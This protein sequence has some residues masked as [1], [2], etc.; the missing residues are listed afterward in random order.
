M[1]PYNPKTTAFSAVREVFLERHR[2]RSAHELESSKPHGRQFLIKL[3]GI[4]GIDEASK[5]VGF[6]VCAAE[7]A[8][9]PL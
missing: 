3:S 4:N 9:E 1:N 5:W 2:S 6:E 7:Y 8:L